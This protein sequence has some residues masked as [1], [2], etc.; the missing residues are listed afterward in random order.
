MANRS[1]TAAVV[2]TAFVSA[3]ALWLG[4]LALREARAG[5]SFDFARWELTTVANKWLYALGE[6]LRDDPPADEALARYFALSD[7]HSA[8]GRRLESTVEAAIEGRIDA[9]IRD[10]DLSFLLPL[11]GP[12]AVWPPVDF[13]LS[14]SPRVLVVSPRDEIK[15]I[16]DLPLRLDFT[17]EELLELERLTETLDGSVSALIVTTGGVATYPAIVADTRSYRRTVS[18]A[19]H[20]WMHHYL[21]FYPLGRAFFDDA[22]TR[23]IN[24]TVAD[25]AGDEIEAGVIARFGDPPPP[26]PA[27]DPPEVDRAAVLRELR[28]EVDALLAEGKVAEAEQRMEEVRLFLE[29]NGIFIRR[30]NQAH[31]AWFGTYAAR[32][33]AVDPLGP[34]LREIRERSG[35]LARFLELIRGVTSRDDVEELLEDMQTGRRA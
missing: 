11:P 17:T 9:V 24:E 5:D 19:A 21:T 13:E 2:A 22:D 35:S 1:V 10:E 29:E 7:R 23:T 12:V 14:R 32:A 15:R 30:I 33:D 8:E 31:F 26:R 34:Q 3:F 25:I 4:L 20:E 28:L 18:T 6:P 16:V 27:G